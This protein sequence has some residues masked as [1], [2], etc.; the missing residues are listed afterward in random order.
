MATAI[1]GAA[2]LAAM[3]TQTSDVVIDMPLPP[4]R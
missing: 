2:F 3:I 4:D 1:V